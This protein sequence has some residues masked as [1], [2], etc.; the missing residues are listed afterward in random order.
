M[1]TLATLTGAA[2][3]ALVSSVAVAQ[4]P[5]AG[6]QR[7]T[8]MPRADLDSLVDARM[9]AIPA[10]LKL[11]AEQQKLWPPVEQ[12][13]RAMAAERLT[14]WEQRR[15]A[16]PQNQP[17][18]FMTR[19][20]RRA[21]WVGQR[22]ERL[23]ALSMAVKPLWA[24]LDERQKRILPILMRPPGGMG[25][26]RMAWRRGGGWSMGAGMM[27]QGMGMGMGMERGRP[28]PRQP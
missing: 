9:A 26:G 14:Q 28:G 8:Q 10:G 3:L 27:D 2:A 16:Q 13:I 6:A 11:T 21:E 23:K 24:S 17:A 12:A 7:P 18:D 4:A 1:K 19:I 20:E 5:A 22:A 15:Q 25:G